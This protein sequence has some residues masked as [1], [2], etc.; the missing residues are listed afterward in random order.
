MM[1]VV[2][3][4]CRNRT[5][6]Q[7]GGNAPRDLKCPVCHGRFRIT[8]SEVVPYGEWCIS[9]ASWRVRM[10]CPFCQQHYDA[11]PQM[12]PFPI[13]CSFCGKRFLVPGQGNQD[14]LPSDMVDEEIIPC[15]E[16]CISSS[17]GLLRVA[18]PGCGQRYATPPPPESSFAIDCSYCKLR[19]VVPVCTEEEK[20]RLGASP[21]AEK[22]VDPAA[23]SPPN[24]VSAPAD[25]P[26]PTDASAETFAPVDVPAPASAPA[27]PVAPVAAPAPA[28]APAK[29]VAPVP[30]PA[31]ASAP[32]KPVAPVTAPAPA[33]A[34]AKPVAPVTAPAPAS[35]P[36]K[37]VAPVPAPAPASAPSGI[38]RGTKPVGPGAM[39]RLAKIV[40]SGPAVSPPGTARPGTGKDV[41]GSGHG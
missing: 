24:E 11:R 21:V 2:C 22:P 10:V 19:F 41:S 5:S 34:P 27:K 6:L 18:C 25:V 35:A 31:P 30:A 12:Q 4:L 17:S 3:P 33:S 40:A 20:L 39:A 15:G 23:A 37:P 36:A 32:A 38:G 7:G 9:E 8:G 1:V 14:V 26:L 16:W 28:S 13:D 29:P